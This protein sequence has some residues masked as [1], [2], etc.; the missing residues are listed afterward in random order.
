M[1]ALIVSSSTA[2][3]VAVA[4]GMPI[5]QHPPHRPVLAQLAHTVPTLDVLGVETCIGVR[6][7]GLTFRH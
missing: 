7:Q 5:A 2:P 1:Y 6:V 4:V 3:T